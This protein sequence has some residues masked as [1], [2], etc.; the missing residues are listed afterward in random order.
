[1]AK[2]SVKPSKKMELLLIILCLLHISL[3]HLKQRKEYCRAAVV[4]RKVFDLPFILILFIII[5]STW[6]FLVLA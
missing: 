4:L 3:L 5:S 2:N 6:R 1:M